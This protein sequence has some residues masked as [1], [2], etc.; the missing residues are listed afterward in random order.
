[1]PRKKKE[2]KKKPKP[3]EAPPETHVAPP[4][5]VGPITQE[6]ELEEADLT[7]DY[8]RSLAREAL[9]ASAGPWEES[10]LGA[11]FQQMVQLIKRHYTKM[12]EIARESGEKTLSFAV[13]FNVCR[14][15]APGEVK[16]DIA[17]SQNWKDNQKVAVPDP[18]QNELPLA[19][20][21]TKATPQKTQEELDADE[22]AADALRMK[23]IEEQQAW[24]RQQDAHNAAQR[25]AE[26]DQKTRNPDEDPP[27]PGTIDPESLG[28]EDPDPDEGDGAR[29][30]DHDPNC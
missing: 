1:M 24:Q 26:F 29:P 4:P 19:I 23:E 11:C 13:K 27:H 8:W 25:E 17:Y 18:D 16:M 20:T 15:V 2:T 21:K 9:P 22:A 5:A 14:K 12:D 28:G 3:T 10:E 7:M 30:D 6:S